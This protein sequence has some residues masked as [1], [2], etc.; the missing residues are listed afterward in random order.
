[1]LIQSFFFHQLSVKNEILSITHSILWSCAICT[2]RYHKITLLNLPVPLEP[3]PWTPHSSSLIFIYKSLRLFGETRH[4]PWRC[5]K[6][7][8]FF[9]LEG[10]YVD[11]KRAELKFLDE[12]LNPPRDATTSPGSKPSDGEISQAWRE[13][14]MEFGWKFNP[15]KRSC[16]S[17]KVVSNR[18]FKEGNNKGLMWCKLIWIDLLWI[19][20]GSALFA[21]AKEAG[22]NIEES[23]FHIAHIFWSTKHVHSCND[24]APRS[25]C[26]AE[27][28]FC[29]TN[30]Q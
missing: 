23:W 13:L 21:P 24:F 7:T 1:M 11:I 28:S 26:T 20:F 10:W 17:E 16:Q 29:T 15:L 14:Y 27:R 25:L 3:C 5:G 12:K 18:Q 9:L 30:L 2:Y 4:P 19:F 22:V 8:F 6:Q